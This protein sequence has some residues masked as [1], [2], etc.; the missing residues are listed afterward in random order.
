MTIKKLIKQCEVRLEYLKSQLQSNIQ[1][2][3]TEMILKIE[4][5][6]AETEQ[7]LTDLNSLMGS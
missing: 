2:N 4:T 1:L 5:E 7:T 3:N 6:I